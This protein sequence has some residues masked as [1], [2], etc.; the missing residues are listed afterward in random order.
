MSA[1]TFP[2]GRMPSSPYPT[3]TLILR[4]PGFPGTSSRS[5]PSA[6][7]LPWPSPHLRKRSTAN[8]STFQS[9]R[10]GTVQTAIWAT[11]AWSSR[12]AVAR[13]CSTA[14][15]SRMPALSTTYPVKAGRSLSGTS[16]RTAGAASSATR[17]RRSFMEASV[18]RFLRASRNRAGS[19]REVRQGA[20]ETRRRQLARQLDDRHLGALGRVAQRRQASG[21]APAALHQHPVGPPAAHLR[22]RDGGAPDVA[23]L[24]QRPR[25]LPHPLLVVGHHQHPRP[26]LRERERQLDHEPAAL[27]RRALGPEVAPVLLG[28]VPADAQPPPGAQARDQ[29]GQLAAL[30]ARAGVPHAEPHVAWARSEER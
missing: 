4:W 23:R 27:P 16:A 30:D 20:R 15:W 3:S 6:R 5:N 9:P 17:A 18:A 21:L 29:L 2:S 11:P 7:F 25:H 10:S 24:A 1:P 8:S 26:A 28:D 13:I 19:G 12:E 14:P 22:D